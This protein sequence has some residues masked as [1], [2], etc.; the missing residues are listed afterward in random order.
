MHQVYG[1]VDELRIVVLS[2]RLQ[3]AV[4]VGSEGHEGTVEVV[5]FYDRARHCAR[6][7]TELKT[8]HCFVHREKVFA[9]SVEE[10]HI[11]GLV[12]AVL[13][14]CSMSNVSIISTLSA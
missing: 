13:E 4:D 11:E 1:L 12:E 3:A 14:Q 7:K 10:R 8:R 5:V 9:C 6:W 2:E